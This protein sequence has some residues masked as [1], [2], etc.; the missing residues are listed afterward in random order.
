VIGKYPRFYIKE[1]KKME[2]QIKKL[3]EIK[4]KAALG[5]GVE[6]IAK[7]HAAGKLTARERIEALLDPGS[8]NELNGLVGHA[9]GI[10]D[11]GIITGHGRI[12]GRVVCVFADDA[13]V[14]GGSRGY[15]TGRKH[16][17]IH[18]MALNMGVPIIG[19]NESPGGRVVRPELAG[20]DDPFRVSDE[21]HAGSVFY[22]NTQCSGAIP[23]ISAILG[24][25]SGGGVYSPALTDFILI[26]DQIGKMFITGPRVVKSVMG[27]D[28][29]FEE[30]GGASVHSRISGVADFRIKDETECLQTVRKLLSYLPPSWKGKPPEVKMGDDPERFND[31]LS[32]IVPEDPKK[33]Y[34]MHKV[35]KEVVDSKEFLEVKKEYASEIIVGFAR[36]DNRAVGIVANQP[37]VLAGSMS[38]NSSDK[39]ARF[40]R[41]CDAFNIPIVLLVDCVGYLP[42]KAEEY[43]GIIRHGAKVLYALTEATVPKVA[44]LMRKVYGGATVGMGTTPGLGT[45]L[46]FAWPNAEVG[47]M[48][49]EQVVELFYAEDIRKAADP[50]EFRKQKIKEYRDRYSN[51]IDISSQSTQMQDIIDPR[52]TRRCLVRS[53]ALL[54]NKEVLI[55]PKKH[56]NMPL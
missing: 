15:L 32:G 52:E 31:S 51:V 27:E 36:M 21:K 45:D 40:I 34:D 47:A 29:S 46:V 4:A 22:M 6:K 1:I 37:S 19:L 2:D 38:I 43:G 50:A 44:I 41:F 39:Q 48:G 56:G 13:T 16:Y 5:G 8:F 7:Q 17:T 18:E 42:G 33:V 3:R 10:P 12:D 24:N 35:I 28:L 14:L 53:L 9:R 49:A 11:D 20:S 26:V 23:Q 30:L 54:A 25:C 55:R